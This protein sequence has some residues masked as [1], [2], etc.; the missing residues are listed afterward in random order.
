M[1]RRLNLSLHKGVKSS[2]HDYMKRFTSSQHEECLLHA[3]THTQ[4]FTHRCS[5]MYMWMVCPYVIL[6]ICCTNTCAQTLLHINDVCSQLPNW[7]VSF[8]KTHYPPFKFTIRS[9]SVHC[10]RCS[11]GNHATCYSTLTMWYQDSRLSSLPNGTKILP[12]DGSTEN[13]KLFILIFSFM[14][15]DELRDLIY[16]LSDSWFFFL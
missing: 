8:R 1:L 6:P 3:H 9:M 12:K 10:D 16:I 11:N 14:Q 13:R 2:Q 5:N 4:T 15:R 7:Y